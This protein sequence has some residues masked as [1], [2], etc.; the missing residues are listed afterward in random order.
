[1]ALNEFIKDIYGEKKIIRNNV[2]P[3]EFVYMGAG[4]MFTI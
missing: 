1:M 3:E 4:M 2:I